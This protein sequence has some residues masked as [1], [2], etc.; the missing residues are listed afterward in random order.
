M[1][2]I[3]KDVSH[4]GLIVHHRIWGSLTAGGEVYRLNILMKIVSILRYDLGLLKIVEKNNFNIS[5]LCN[6][7]VIVHVIL[8]NRI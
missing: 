3:L 5:D 1:R 6:N 7:C 2:Q 8:S 4:K